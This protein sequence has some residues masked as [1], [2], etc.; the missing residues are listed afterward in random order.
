MR[1]TI[2]LLCFCLGLHSA[3]AQQQSG[4][5]TF[6]RSAGFEEPTEGASR[7]LLMKNGNTLFFQFTV[8]KGVNV[9]VYDH[10]HR[11]TGAVNSRIRSWKQKKMKRADL[12]ALFE[13]DGNAVVFLEQLIKKHPTLYRLV[14]DG[15]TGKLLR[16][17][18]LAKN[19]RLHMGDSH[20]RKYGRFDDVQ[21]IVKRDPGSEYYA[22]GICNGESS[23]KK[24]HIEV[25]HFAPNHKE[26]NRAFFES[27]GD[28]YRYLVSP[29]IY[30]NR[31]EFVFISGYAYNTKATE[32]KDSRVVIGRLQKGTRQFESKALDYTGDYENPMLVVK[33]RKEDK[34]VYMLNAFE[35]KKDDNRGIMSKGY[36]VMDA[37]EMNI[38]D[39]ATQEVKNHYLIKHPKLSA[40]VEQYI[41]VKKKNKKVYNGVIQDFRLNSDSTI[42]YLFEYMNNYVSTR[43]STSFNSRTGAASTTTRSVLCT[44]LGDIGIMNTDLDGKEL[45]SYAIN[46]SQGIERSLNMFLI[47]RRKQSSWHFRAGANY[48]MMPGFLSYDYIFVN[49]KDYVFFNDSPVN[50]DNEDEDA[51]S[52]KESGAVSNWNTACATFDGNKVM[53]PY[54]FGEPKEK[55]EGRF[56]QLEMITTSEDNKTMATMMIERLGREKKA[57]IVWGN[58]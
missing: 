29:D 4:A 34:L 36:D 14:F 2:F 11:T 13:V 17:D 42:T 25:V 54:L 3:I 55:D 7:L 30:V 51:H 9:N 28:T 41:K 24:E 56:C 18:E 58:F 39:P 35:V 50:L 31:D 53:K 23:V 57:Y 6:T 15:K 22:I 45:R 33:Y 38:I 43:T 46:K 12:K 8:K 44:T 47:N 10:K 49:G 5:P 32:G 26:I 40:Y 21:F 37:L 52:K 19:N 20:K 27:P 48:S 16:E 1:E